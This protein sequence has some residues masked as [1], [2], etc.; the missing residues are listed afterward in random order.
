MRLLLFGLWILV[1]C[2]LANALAEDGGEPPIDGLEDEDESD[3]RMEEDYSETKLEGLLDMAESTLNLHA[4]H[5]A[6]FEQFASQLAALQ[7]RSSRLDGLEAELRERTLRVDT[8]IQ[9]VNT[10]QLEQLRERLNATVQ[11]EIEAVANAEKEASTEEVD[12]S[13]DV[14]TSQFVS[15]QQLESALNPESLLQE[16]EEM[17]NELNYKVVQE[18]VAN[19]RQS[20]ASGSCTTPLEAAQIIQ[21]TFLQADEQI[22]HAR[23]AS[24]VHEMT[25]STY[26]PPPKQEQLL[27]N[28]WWRKY[29][30]EDW[31]RLLPSGWEGWNVGIPSSL[32]HSLVGP[33]QNTFICDFSCLFLTFFAPPS[34]GHQGRRHFASRGNLRRQHSSWIML[35]HERKPGSCDATTSTSNGA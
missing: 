18:E 12:P 13:D 6:V 27:G 15:L 17:L 4:Q 20:H 11:K 34:A 28:V 33:M 24:I 30:P 29:I 25:S 22:D 32:Y 10:L 21:S 19:Y 14:D 9:Q 1:G 35:A 31:E 7:E 16:S 3:N 2:Y 23:G 5:A 26:Q 8:L